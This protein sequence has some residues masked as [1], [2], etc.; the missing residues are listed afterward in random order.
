MEQETDH[1]S[2]DAFQQF[3]DK[4]FPLPSPPPSGAGGAE[5]AAFEGLHEEQ[6]RR[7]AAA[8]RQL[9]VRALGFIH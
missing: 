9:L 4:T 6:S 3:V 7:R 2:L 1:E 5:R 8:E